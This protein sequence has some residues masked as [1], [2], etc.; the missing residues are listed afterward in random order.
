MY[1]GDSRNNELMIFCVSKAMTIAIH[2]STYDG[3]RVAETN[4]VLQ[5]AITR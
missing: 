3:H 1:I 4:T 5:Q 2:S